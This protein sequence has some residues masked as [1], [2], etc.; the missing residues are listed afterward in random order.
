MDTSITQQHSSIAQRMPGAASGWRSAFSRRGQ[1][2]GQ[3]QSPR[4]VSLARTIAVRGAVSVVVATGIILGV[5]YSMAASQG[6]Q[7]AARVG[8]TGTPTFFF[9]GQRY[10]GDSDKESL[11]KAI[12]EALG[13]R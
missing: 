4:F 10:P 3:E 9:N 12:E 13:V 6:V 11:T 2:A 8:A 5:F 1:A 7:D